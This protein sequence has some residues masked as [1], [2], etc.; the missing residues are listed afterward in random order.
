MMFQWIA[1]LALSALL[2]VI[3]RGPLRVPGSHGFHR[4]FAWECI[5]AL[6]LLNIDVSFPS[7]LPWYHLLSSALQLACLLPLGLGVGTLVVWGKPVAHRETE[8]H[9]F[10]FEKTS[11][12]VTRGIYRY[13]RHPMYCSLL[14]LAW[15]VYFKAPAWHGVLLAFSATAFLY[16]TARADEAECVR[17]F[18]PAY[19]A[20]MNTSKRF[21]PYLF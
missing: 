13:I 6:F 8:P 21:V 20:Y 12:L 16:L 4:F 11:V 7:P 19:L 1:F 15:A 9:L 17:F 2:M 18:G 10:D 14:L 5:L 3:S